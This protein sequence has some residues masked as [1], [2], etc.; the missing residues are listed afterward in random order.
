MLVALRSGIRQAN[1]QICFARNRLKLLLLK[2]DFKKAIKNKN[3]NLISR[4]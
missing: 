4:V 3:N 2:G 1:R